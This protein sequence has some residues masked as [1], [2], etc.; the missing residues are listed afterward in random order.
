MRNLTPLFST[1]GGLGIDMT[2][3]QQHNQD[4]S[5]A[6][7]SN[8]DSKTSGEGIGE[9]TGGNEFLAKGTTKKGKK[10]DA[11]AWMKEAR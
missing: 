7:T 11:Y 3:A 10:K 4:T 5:P 6:S 9:Q 2:G 1:C 8:A